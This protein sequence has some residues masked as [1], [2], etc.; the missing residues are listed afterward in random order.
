MTTQA[1]QKPKARRTLLS[2]GFSCQI[3]RVEIAIIKGRL[4]YYRHLLMDC[5]CARD[6]AKSYSCIHLRCF[7]LF[8][9]V[10]FFGPHLWHTE[11]PRLKV[12][13]EL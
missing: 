6:C 11:V 10:C 13:S 1:S 7:V 9:F 12:E 4:T 5:C 2:R 8:C 3:P